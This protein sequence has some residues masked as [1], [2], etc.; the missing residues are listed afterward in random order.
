MHSIQI[1]RLFS[2]AENKNYIQA[3]VGLVF[4]LD[5]RIYI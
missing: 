2:I 1:E 5:N 3:S 4:V